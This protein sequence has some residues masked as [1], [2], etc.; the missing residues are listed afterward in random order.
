M[1]GNNTNNI[2]EYEALLDGMASA[3][4]WRA[5]LEKLTSAKCQMHLKIFGDSE[6]VV[7]QMTGQYKVRAPH[8]ALLHQKAK[9]LAATFDS[10]SYYHVPRELNKEAD[11]AANEALDTGKSFTTVNLV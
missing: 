4:K 10:V 2:A 6:L 7:R 8:L 5:G 3:Q 11:A 1:V 9:D